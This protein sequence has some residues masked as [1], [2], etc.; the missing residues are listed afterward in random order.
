MFSLV[1]EL[2]REL[3]RAVN[4]LADGL[5]AVAGAIREKPGIGLSSVERSQREAPTREEV[6]E[7]RIDTEKE[8]PSPATATATAATATATA[9]AT[10]SYYDPEAAQ[11]EQELEEL[12]LAQYWDSRR[13]VTDPSETELR[14]AIP[15]ARKETPN[16]N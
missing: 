16:G 9:T 1:R 14:V 11:R 10:V 5:F 6:L 7:Y 13:F 4:N 2:V 15:P 8:G 12:R 3:V